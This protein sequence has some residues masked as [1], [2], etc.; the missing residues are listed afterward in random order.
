LVENREL[1]DLS[2]DPGQQRNVM[3]EHPEVVNRLRAE[4]D[5]WWSGVAP[6]VNDH[7]AITIGSD[8]ENPSQLSPA[9]WEDSFLDQGR[10]VRDGLRRNGAWNVVVDRDGDYEFEVRRWPRE[11][12]APLSS[13]LPAVK[14]ADG[15]FTAGV[16][17]PIAK[18]R[19]KIGNF[20]ALREAAATDK[21][22]TFAASLTAGRTRL[23]TWL[24]DAEGNELA[25][26]YYVY[27]RRK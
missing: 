23:Q 20:N 21:S 16:A 4:Y 25:G 14:H 2:R 17:L 15:A 24:L 1:Y 26:A 5:K 7:S 18:V 10:Q 6:Q 22:I 27:V 13:G 9:D 8:A 12:D 19:L 11:A 3:A